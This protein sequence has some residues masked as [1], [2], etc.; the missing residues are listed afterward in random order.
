MASDQSDGKGKGK[1]FGKGK[2][3]SSWGSQRPQTPPRRPVE[4]PAT[5]PELRMPYTAPTANSFGV[6]AAHSRPGAMRRPQSQQ[7]QQQ[8]QEQ[9]QEQAQDYGQP[10]QQQQQEEQLLQ[11][12]QQHQQLLQQQHEPLPHTQQMEQEQLQY[13]QEPMDEAFESQNLSFEWAQPTPK[14]ASPAGPP[15]ALPGVLPPSQYASPAV[16]E[17]SLSHGV[18]PASQQDLA[19]ATLFSGVPRTPPGANPSTPPEQPCPPLDPSRSV[20]SPFGIQSSLAEGAVPRTPPREEALRVKEEELYAAALR[21]AA[22]SRAAAATTA[23]ATATAS[24]AATEAEARPVG[25]CQDWHF[26][27]PM[28]PPEFSGACTPPQNGGPS[29]PGT[30]PQQFPSWGQDAS[31]FDHGFEETGEEWQNTWGADTGVDGTHYMDQS[32]QQQQQEYQQQQQEYSQQ[33][34]QFQ[35]QKGE[36]EADAADTWQGWGGQES[37][38]LHQEDGTA[39]ENVDL[40][41]Q[42]WSRLHD[43]VTALE[44]LIG[45]AAA[46]ADGDTQEDENDAEDGHTGNGQPLQNRAAAFNAKVQELERQL[47]E[48]EGSGGS[49]SSTAIPMASHTTESTVSN[50][51]TPT[52]R[53]RRRNPGDSETESEEEGGKASKVSKA[54][55]SVV[56]PNQADLSEALDSL[57]EWTFVDEEPE[58]PDENLTSEIPLPP[59]SVEWTAST[60]AEVA[61]S[62]EELVKEPPV[63][64]RR[65][66]VP[67]VV[68]TT[69]P[70]ANLAESLTAALVGAYPELTRSAES[71]RSSATPNNPSEPGVAAAWNRYAQAIQKGDE[72]TAAAASLLGLPVED[73]DSN[74]MTP[75]HL[76]QI[77]HEQAD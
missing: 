13:Q 50:P 65:Q 24:S 9:E 18:V 62:L 77:Q 1:D 27:A 39:L 11:Q 31:Q 72:A 43:E 55:H 12:Q 8:Q 38:Q 6:A 56:S 20:L 60:R 57:A 29:A 59:S 70:P 69:A 35:Q 37:S 15:T 16:V 52:G 58:D 19:S 14:W 7:L 46:G 45:A 23:T 74:L 53:H 28:T 64:S 32:E 21:R 68:V 63:L 42:E 73:A 3:G 76:D 41:L 26:Q 54:A 5:P 49:T 17:G 33:Y 51:E 2:K 40:R 48:A 36:W 67:E 34:H 30:P 75:N 25:V 61:N 10:Q 47:R 66:N 44:A 4:A 71:R 22:A